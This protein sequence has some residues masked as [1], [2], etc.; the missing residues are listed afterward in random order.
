MRTMTKKGKRGILVIASVVL[1]ILI[2]I[3]WNSIAGTFGF[4]GKHVSD[5][6]ELE[7]SSFES[8]EMTNAEVRETANY[9][10]PFIELPSDKR[11]PKPKLM[12]KH[13]GIMWNGHAAFV[14]ANGGEYTT[15]GS[16]FEKYGKEYGE[17]FLLKTG[18][19][20]DYSI[21]QQNLAEFARGYLKSEG[22][23]LSKGT[24]IVSFM[25]DNAEIYMQQANKLLDVVSKEF[26]KEPGYLR[27][28]IFLITGYS[29]GEDKAMGL[30]EWKDNPESA[31]GEVFACYPQDGDQNLIIKWA[32][33]NGLKINP[34]G[35]T[36]CEDAVNF[37][38]VDGFMEAARA[39]GTNTGDRLVVKID[40]ETNRT[41]KT[42][43][44]HS[45]VI[46]GA[47][48]WTPGDVEA[49]EAAKRKGLDLVS[50]Y[51][52]HDNRHQMP[53]VLV[54]INKVIE[55]HSGIFEAIV[56]G[57]V[58][59]GD[60]IKVHQESFE[61]A[62][63]AMSSTFSAQPAS[64]W[65]KYFGGVAEKTVNGLDIRLG[66]S[67]TVNLADNLDAFGIGDDARA[68]FKSSYEL[69]GGY[70]FQLYPDYM[71]ERLPYYAAVNTKPLERVS[72]KLAKTNEITTKSQVHMKESG[73]ITDKVAQRSYS[74]EFQ[75][76]SAVLTSSGIAALELMFNDLNTHDLRITV[77]GHTDNTGTN[78]V[79]QPLSQKRAQAVVDWLQSKSSQSFPQKRF[80]EVKGY[81]SSQPLTGYDPNSNLG[82]SKNRRVEIT[83]GY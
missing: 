19:Q 7:Q 61:Y 60:Q 28:E 64:Y 39:W 26:G 29:D 77:S 33:D 48:T 37:H 49:F 15:R 54:S 38:F 24:A 83:V 43:Q 14:A 10:V 63:E 12:L 53:C 25:G 27:A 51:S 80:A 65:K 57:T 36:Y 42:K 32:S 78:E 6:K 69:F 71:P 5:V 79:N 59:F 22:K 20:D 73:R 17:A 23:D 67:R 31:L 44:R 11:I 58:R 40:P 55:D 30:A 70:M 3:K 82:R 74:V 41:V 46:H 47:G 72:A 35:E 45:H 9:D 16:L 50:L 52:T 56:E 13:E 8:D 66:G 2:M 1:A 4:L 75:L 76:G 62:M 18:R 81:G 68:T 34:D 21:Q